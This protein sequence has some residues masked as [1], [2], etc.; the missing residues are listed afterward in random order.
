MI[1]NISPNN[2]RFKPQD[3]ILVMGH[4]DDLNRLL[5]EH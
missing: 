3:I 2:D 5:A 4:Q 1:M